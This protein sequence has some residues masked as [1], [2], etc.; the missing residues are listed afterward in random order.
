MRKIPQF[1]NNYS[2]NV[3]PLWLNKNYFGISL[4]HNLAVKKLS[5][6]G[7]SAWD[8][9]KISEIFRISRYFIS[10]HQRLHVAQPNKEWFEQWLVG[11][12]DGDGSF[13]VLRLNFN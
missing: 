10:S 2:S 11:M 7:K 1:V 4:F 3:I 12:T 13:S 8:K 5:T 6:W 9:V